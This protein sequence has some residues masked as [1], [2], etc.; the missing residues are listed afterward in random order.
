MM[1][2]MPVSTPGQSTARPL[3]SELTVTAEAPSKVCWGAILA[4]LSAALALQVLFMM[5]GAGLG[6]AIYSPLTNDNPVADLGTGA[7][8]VQGISAVFSLWFGGWI[9]GRFAP[10]GVRMTGWLHGFVV[11]CAA[12][13]AGVLLVSFGAGWVLGDLSKLVGGG[14]SMAGKPAAALAEGATDTAKDALKQSTD[15]LGSFVDEAIGRVPASNATGSVRAKRE[16]AFAVGRLFNPIQQANPTEARAVVVQALVEHTGASAAEAERTV[17]AWTASYERLKTDLA[18][19]KE[20]AETKARE[21]AEKAANA[22]AV[23]SLCAFVAFTMG[24]LAA[25]FG[26]KHGAMCARKHHLAIS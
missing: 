24:A 6:F 23:F 5:L 20:Q 3:V 19:A 26:G 2:S 10:L 15:T 13:V 22:L 7:V 9:A 11:W 4:G 16:V 17:A 25:A 18:A 12:T 8:V 14:L 21:A 1:Q